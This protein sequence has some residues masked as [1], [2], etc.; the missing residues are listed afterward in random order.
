MPGVPCDDPPET[1]VA[2]LLLTGGASRRM[3]RDKATLL[4][5]DGRPSARRTAR[6]L[7]AVAD[8]VLEVGPG[9]ASIRA[10]PDGWPGA[11][12]LTAVASG[13]AALRTLGWCGRVLVVATDLPRLD[14]ALLRWLATHPYPGTV[15]PVVDGYPQLLCA[16]YDADTVALAAA[17]VGAGSRRMRDLIEGRPAHR[18]G[19]DEWGGV[20]ATGSFRDADTPEAWAAAAGSGWT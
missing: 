17:L 14:E 10:V 15:V 3:G 2:A 19:P 6:L 8:P 20:S 16:R 5:A 7:A 1:G 18:A 9:H 4:A 12:P 11:G 13:A